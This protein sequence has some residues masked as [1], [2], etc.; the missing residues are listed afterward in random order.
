MMISHIFIQSTLQPPLSLCFINVSCFAFFAD[1]YL[2]FEHVK[3][4]SSE[5]R[6]KN[7]APPDTPRDDLL[8]LPIP[9]PPAQ[10]LHPQPHPR[11]LIFSPDEDFPGPPR[12]PPPPPPQFSPRIKLERHTP[13]QFMC[14]C[15]RN[16]CERSSTHSAE[17]RPLSRRSVATPQPSERRPTPHLYK[18]E[19]PS[20]CA[21]RARTPHQSVPGIFPPPASPRCINTLHLTGT[22]VTVAVQT[23]K[24]RHMPVTC[25]PSCSNN[26]SGNGSS[27]SSRRQ[28]VPNLNLARS[29]TP[30]VN[31]K[32]DQSTT[33]EDLAGISEQQQQQQQQPPQPQQQQQRGKGRGKGWWWHRNGRPRNYLSQLTSISN[34]ISDFE[35]SQN[36]GVAIQQMMVFSEQESEFVR[37][38]ENLD[39]DIHE[40]LREKKRMME[41]LGRL[42]TLRMTKLQQLVKLSGAPSVGVTEHYN[43]SKS[44]VEPKTLRVYH[45]DSS[46][47]GGDAMETGESSTN[48]LCTENC[49]KNH[50]VLPKDEVCVQ[51]TTDNASVVS[52]SQEK[53]PRIRSLSF[54]HTSSNDSSNES[55]SVRRQRCT[56]TCHSPGKSTRS[57]DT[58]QATYLGPFD[59]SEE[60]YQQIP[61]T[62]HTGQQSASNTDSETDHDVKAGDM[63]GRSSEALALFDESIIQSSSG[64][65]RSHSLSSSAEGDIESEVPC[66]HD[67]EGD[68][69]VRHSRLEQRRLSNENG[70]AVVDS[71]EQQEEK[72]SVEHHEG[73]LKAVV[74]LCTEKPSGSLQENNPEQENSGARPLQCG[75]SDNALKIKNEPEKEEEEIRQSLEESKSAQCEDVPSKG[76]PLHILSYS[77]SNRDIKKEEEDT[78]S[79]LKSWRFGGMYWQGRINENIS[80][81]IFHILRHHLR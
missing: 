4:P 28:Y 53:G 59:A 65:N 75:D 35:F 72:I 31:T 76:K 7:P 25:E 39:Q 33:T 9:P 1:S 62:S 34:S 40:L 27:N 32:V 26:Y 8:P 29:V 81:G 38:I 71:S 42:Q 67:D 61:S 19:P 5:E 30:L 64:R 50:G 49:V 48:T 74:A 10:A 54:S 23:E 58:Q 70:E 6:P 78:S 20:P 14:C 37:H 68:Q 12:P 55:Q 21:S 51:S 56:S 11:P 80:Q 66:D 16:E 13:V 15:M 24:D 63:T 36:S 77:V 79:K 3:R 60:F 45:Q 43:G 69:K 41:E 73:E 57:K 47:D 46:S 52:S 44:N 18:M 17:M 22:K 2:K